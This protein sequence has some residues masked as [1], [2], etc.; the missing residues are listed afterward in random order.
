M[1]DEIKEIINSIDFGHIIL[2]FISLISGIY[3]IIQSR[4][5][6]KY[7]ILD[8]TYEKKHAAYSKFITKL[9]ELQNGLRPS[10]S[11]TFKR[12]ENLFEKMMLAENEEDT[13]QAFL[14][15][16]THMIKYMD[17]ALEPVL[18]LKGEINSLYLDSSDEMV[19]M[20]DRYKELADTLHTNTSN[21]LN[22]AYPTNVDQAT[23]RWNEILQ[24]DGWQE[25]ADLSK[26]MITQMRKEIQ[27]K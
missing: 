27:G 24:N 6:R 12:P 15:L 25:M 13:V 21:T 9:D 8:R 20:I 22:L 3:S 5:L 11:E 1:I 19:T 26:K 10:L 18:I 2:I 14:G 7:Q 4:K 23:S 16:N 17:K